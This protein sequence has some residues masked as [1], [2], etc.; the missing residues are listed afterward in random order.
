MQFSFPSVLRICSIGALL[1]LSIGTPHART[2]TADESIDPSQSIKRKI[3]GEH[4]Y[5]RIM[6]VTDQYVR[7]VVDQ[8]GI[9]V[10]VKL[11]QPDGKIVAQSDRLIGAYGPETIT[12]VARVRGSTNSKCVR[13]RPTRRWAY[14]L[15]ML[16]SALRLFRTRNRITAQNVFMQAEQLREQATPASVGPG[17]REIRRSTS[18]LERHR[19][20][21]PAKQRH[22]TCIGLVYDLLKR[23]R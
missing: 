7:L 22:L 23:D 18:N 15:K 4:H 6:L 12:W 5:Y 16:E 14:E 1:L 3:A 2:Q 21:A 13:L 9:D 10:S 8:R 20:I 11:Y 19:E 17:N